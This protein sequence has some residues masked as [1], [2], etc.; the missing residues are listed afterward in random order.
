MTTDNHEM[1]IDLNGLKQDAVLACPYCQKGKTYSYGA[2]G[3]ES[4]N[5]HNCGRLVLW[6]FDRMM[7]YRAKAKKFAG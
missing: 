5:C 3:K 1:I 6:D 2:K 7:A 4:C